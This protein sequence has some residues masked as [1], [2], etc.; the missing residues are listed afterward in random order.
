MSNMVVFAKL[1][2][3]IGFPFAGVFNVQEW[4]PSVKEL[5]RKPEEPEESETP[6]ENDLLWGDLWHAVAIHLCEA[7]ETSPCFFSFNILR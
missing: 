4:L 7:P 2:D 6:E 3:G 5:M 1:N